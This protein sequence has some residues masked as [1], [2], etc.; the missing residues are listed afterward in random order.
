MPDSFKAISALLSRRLVVFCILLLSALL[1]YAPAL[2]G[3]LLWDD[4]YLIRENP[5]FK[6][7]V[8][9]LEVFRHW[10]F[11]DSF[12]VYYRPVQNWSYMADYWIWDANPFGYHLTNILL[13]AFGGY[14]LYR[15]LCRLLPRLAPSATDAAA[16]FV[17]WIWV[18]HPVHN[19][20]VAYISG[21][22]DSL[23]AVFA[24]LGWL[25]YLEGRSA[26]SKGK[27]VTL[28][29]LAPVCALLA[30]CSKE[31]ALVWLG[32]FA[33]W[34]VFDTPEPRLRGMVAP[35]LG[36]GGAVLAYYFLR[37]LP[38]PRTPISESSGDSFPARVLLM[39]RALGD[40]TSLMFFPDGLRMER[41]V[42]T[43][44]AY[45]SLPLWQ[46]NIR[47][48]YLS[49][50]GSAT[51]F[52]FAFFS[53]KSLPGRRLRI[54]A[55]LWF[56]IGFLPISNLFPLN[57]QVA[58]HWIYIPSIGFLIFV[59][60]C[61]LALPVGYQRAVAGIAVAGGIALGARTAFRSAEW[62]APEIFYSRMIAEGS[63]SPRI[64]TNL[65]FVY[66]QRGDHERAIR[67]L[68]AGVQKYP[69]VRPRANQSRHQLGGS[70]EEG[71]GKEIPGVREAS[72]GRGSEPVSADVVGRGGH[73]PAAER[74]KQTG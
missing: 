62:A 43:P 44:D 11:L 22:A 28:F 6:S 23:A 9:L 58:E 32:I 33:L 40:Y 55:A 31:I 38:P 15:L 56:L 73:G 61:V 49:I 10:L 29:A 59:A 48:E 12:S 60:G 45:K 68:R 34:L 47:Y 3:D 53:F 8:F 35:L 39:L 54:F 7:P 50:L 14:L 65:G 24:L 57:A 37:H 42:F 36:L 18:I 5:F 41:I 66:S 21:R 70:R 63:D 20:A 27:R 25:A 17:A 69:G 74:G 16:F 72:G 19:A 26:L 30:L 13:H 71:R 46:K 4:F 2:Q 52:C 1:V 64:Y 67:V 51:L